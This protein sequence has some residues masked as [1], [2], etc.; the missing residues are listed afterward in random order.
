MLQL[1]YIELYLMI[2]LND[3][4]PHECMRE[5]Y[6]NIIFVILRNNNIDHTFCQF[7]TQSRFI[8]LVSLYDV[9]KTMQISFITYDKLCACTCALEFCQK[10]SIYYMKMLVRH[11]QPYH[12]CRKTVLRRTSDIWKMLYGKILTITVTNMQTYI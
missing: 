9:Y 4:R 1:S 12:K 11:V 5:K 8:G 6:S 3:L 10:M 2:R 7:A